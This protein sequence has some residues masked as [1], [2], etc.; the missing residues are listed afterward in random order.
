VVIGQ[1]DFV[2]RS[3]NMGKGESRA[4]QGSMYFPNDVV[5]GKTGLFVSDS[6]NN[7]VLYWKE[8]PTENGQPADMVFGQSNFFDNKHNRYTK[9]NA[10]TLNDPY[11]LWLEEEENPD[12]VP[13]EERAEKKPVEENLDDSSPE[14][15]VEDDNTDENIP[16][17]LFKL[18]IAD[19]GN[20]RVAV[21]NELPIM[22]EEEDEEQDDFIEIEDANLL[23]GEDE[24]DDYLGDE[25]EDGQA[26]PPEELPSV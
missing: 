24:D 10:A 23:I 17:Y 15:G 4:D 19:R 7:R 5:A 22:A 16:E 2:S 20:S 1:K 3:P 21:W 26:T 8:V 11:G 13:L 9:P 6:G 14:G 25:D 18:F 12:W